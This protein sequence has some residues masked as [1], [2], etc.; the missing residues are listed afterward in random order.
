MCCWCCLKKPAQFPLPLAFTCCVLGEESALPPRLRTGAKCLPRCGSFVSGCRPAVMPCQQAPR[1][2]QKPSF[3]FCKQETPRH[4][5]STRVLSR[6]AHLL[7]RTLGAITCWMQ[8]LSLLIAGAAVTAT[9][10]SY[11][12]V[13]LPLATILVLA[14]TMSSRKKEGML[15]CMGEEFHWNFWLRNEIF[16]YFC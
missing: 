15:D 7:T 16:P 9:A 13:H 5:Y 2:S 12:T 11:D 10:C 3:H 8:L 6:S 4:R 14:A 1:A